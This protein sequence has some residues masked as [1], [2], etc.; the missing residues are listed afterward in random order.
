MQI[1]QI[2][3]QL[4]TVREH[5]QTSTGLAETARKIRAI[6]YSAVP[7][8]GVGPFRSAVSANI[9]RDA[10]L[11]ICATHEPAATILNEPGRVV[12]RLQELGCKHTAYPYP[13]G[14][15]FSDFAQVTSLAHRLDVA[16]AVL[17][18]AGLTLGY[19]NHAHEFFPYRGSTILDHIF[20]LT[21][22]QHL[23]A[24][25]DTYWVR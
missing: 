13:D 21:H 4:Y 9:M 20:R 23:L 7:I 18:A 16:G 3:A 8:S 10:G 19:H 14:V 24:E 12:E 25:L 5:C 22:E 15:D 1:S 17:H 2:A 6:G 11:I